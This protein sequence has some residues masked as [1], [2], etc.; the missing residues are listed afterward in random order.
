MANEAHNQFSDYYSIQAAAST[1]DDAYSAGAQTS[2]LTA[3]GATDSKSPMLDFKVKVTVG[4]PAENGVIQLYRRNSDG[5][6]TTP[7]PSGNFTGDFVGSMTMDN[8]AT[9]TYYHFRAVNVDPNCTYYMKNKDGVSAL[10]IELF[11]RGATYAP[12]A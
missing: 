12:A 7:A 8:T 4:T 10:T 3:L 11:V 9:S 5:T 6:D 1:A 2:V